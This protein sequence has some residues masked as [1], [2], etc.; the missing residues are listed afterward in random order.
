MR[1]DPGVDGADARADRRFYLSNA[2]VSAGA[3]G[4]IA[5]VLVL[6]SGP[7]GAA[8]DV[9]FLPAV[10]ATLN[11]TATAF[12]C[13][14]WLAVKKRALRIHRACMLAAFSASALFFLSYLTYHYLHGDT[15]YP[16]TGG[17]RTLYLM[18]LASHVLLSV[19]VPPM[20]L[21]ALWFAWRRAFDRHR[22]LARWLFPIWLYVSI[23]GVVIFAMLRSAA[24]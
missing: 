2:L 22:R 8:P 19:L 24:A 20:A 9:S 13:A 14:G 11:A 21:S 12:L 23:T 7:A 17:L 16:G 18:I 10:N 5:Y 6:R 4:L 1:A 3:L 15:R